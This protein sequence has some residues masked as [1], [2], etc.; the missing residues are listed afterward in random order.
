MKSGIHFLSSLTLLSILILGCD[1]EDS[2]PD[3]LPG[4]AV[5]TNSISSITTE[6]A[7]GG[8]NVLDDGGETVTAK[9]IC[10]SVDPDPTIDLPTKTNDGVNVG[11]Y[12]SNMSGLSAGTLYYVRAYASNP[13]GTAYGDQVSFTT[14]GGSVPVLLTNSAS[15][16]TNESAD[17]GGVVILDGDSPITG[18]G[19]CWSTSANPTISS[20]SVLYLGNGTGEFSG[21]LT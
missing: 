16:I 12:V 10:W 21:T 14:D 9:G 19:L 13:A 5:S 4:L 6:T 2:S 17:C 8:G 1:K 15:D 3:T 18:R 11:S 20:D 7:T